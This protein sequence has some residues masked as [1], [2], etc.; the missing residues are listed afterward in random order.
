MTTLN[1]FLKPQ[2][3]DT[4]KRNIILELSIWK[5]QRK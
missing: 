5:R 1:L 3:K 2:Q 4:W